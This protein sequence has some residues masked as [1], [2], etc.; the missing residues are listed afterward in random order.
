MVGTYGI[1][2][3]EKKCIQ[4]F[5]RE[6]KQPVKG[7]ECLLLPFPPLMSLLPFP[8]MPRNKYLIILAL[9]KVTIITTAAAVAMV[10][11]TTTNTINTTTTTGFNNAE[12]KLPQDLQLIKS[13]SAMSFLVGAV[14]TLPLQ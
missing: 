5:L 12:D 2:G 4:G 9:S 13:C 1:Y 14:V 6:T 7:T 3:G 8:L 10:T 11:T